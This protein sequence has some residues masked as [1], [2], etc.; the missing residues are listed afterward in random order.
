MTCYLCRKNERISYLSYYCYNCKKIQDLLSVY[1]D[2]VY[3]VLE[4]VLC[5][6]EDKQNNKIKAEIKSEI[7]YKQDT[8]MSELKDKIKDK[9]K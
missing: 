1:S 9:K 8:L 2:R 3:E 5:R 4:S 6:T 7:N